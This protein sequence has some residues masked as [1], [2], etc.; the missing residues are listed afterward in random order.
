MGT[1]YAGLKIFHFN[2]IFSIIPLSNS[3]IFTPF[4]PHI[5]NMTQIYNQMNIKTNRSWKD[6]R[7]ILNSSS[8]GKMLLIY[9]RKKTNNV[10]FIEKL[11]F[12]DFVYIWSRCFPYTN[13]YFYIEFKIYN[14]KHIQ[15]RTLPKFTKYNS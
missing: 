12:I 13:E 1:F 9:F 8:T 6:V 15:W 2:R 10:H 7:R 3:S 14:T 4:A 11:L 5:I